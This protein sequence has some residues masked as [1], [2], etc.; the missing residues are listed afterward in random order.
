MQWMF[1]YVKAPTRTI[2]TSISL[3]CDNLQQKLLLDRNNHVNCEVL[4]RSTMVD[5]RFVLTKELFPDYVEYHSIHDLIMWK[6]MAERHERYS[7]KYLNKH[8]PV[9]KLDMQTLLS[10]Y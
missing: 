9:R 3:L 1:P 4:P 7:K 2:S 8:L 6:I 5:G 10:T